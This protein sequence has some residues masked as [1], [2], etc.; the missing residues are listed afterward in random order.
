VDTLGKGACF[1]S[2][3][4]TLQPT[5]AIVAGILILLGVPTCASAGH[6]IPIGV[7]DLLH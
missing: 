3:Y 6:L 2:Y 7:P 1:P 4:V 5:P